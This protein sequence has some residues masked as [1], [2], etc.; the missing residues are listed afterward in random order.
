LETL[1]NALSPRLATNSNTR[2]ACGKF[3]RS[4]KLRTLWY[5]GTAAV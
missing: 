4:Q 2:I 5:R 1:A 3:T